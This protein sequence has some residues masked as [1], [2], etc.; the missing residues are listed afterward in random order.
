MCGIFQSSTKSYGRPANY[1]V[2]AQED[3]NQVCHCYRK[4]QRLVQK[5]EVKH[6]KPN[7][8]R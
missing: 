1:R 6:F 8:L 7:Q 2:F 5:F 4:S 3:F